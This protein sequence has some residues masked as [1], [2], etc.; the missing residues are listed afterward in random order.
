MSARWTENLQ[1]IMMH[2]LCRALI[3]SLAEDCGLRVSEQEIKYK[4]A[5]SGQHTR[6]TCSTRIRE[7]EIPL[8]K[9][10]EYNEFPWPFMVPSV[11]DVLGSLSKENRCP[12]NLLAMD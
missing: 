8:P 5:I 1:S 12:T 10:P 6:T 7:I 4:I 3:F 2:V 9:T 11:Y